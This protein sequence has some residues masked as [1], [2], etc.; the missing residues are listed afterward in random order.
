MLAGNQCD[1]ATPVL[2]CAT[3]STDD[4]SLIKFV[5]LKTGWYTGLF[6]WYHQVSKY[7]CCTCWT[8]RDAV[9]TH[10]HTHAVLTSRLV[11]EKQ[12]IW[13]TALTAAGALAKLIVICHN[14]QMPAYE[15]CRPCYR[16]QP[17]QRQRRSSERVLTKKDTQLNDVQSDDSL[18]TS[19][20]PA[21]SLFR[22]RLHVMF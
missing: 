20:D 3:P 5:T 19:P 6:A 7:S 12:Q 1:L 16:T 11:A 9:N 2:Y 15:P 8:T 21:G 17:E 4:A 18:S 10:T 13:T 14:C 22:P